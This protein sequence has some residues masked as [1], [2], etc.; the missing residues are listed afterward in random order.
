MAGAFSYGTG[1]Y[2]SPSNA[3]VSSLMNIAREMSTSY[4]IGSA[5][6][7]IGIMTIIALYR[8]AAHCLYEMM[9]RI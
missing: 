5:L 3:A 4:L 1:R 2:T 9:K 7:E 8:R 6:S